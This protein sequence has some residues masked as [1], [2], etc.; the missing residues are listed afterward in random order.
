MGL[1]EN[2]VIF[3]LEFSD[4]PAG[5]LVFRIRRFLVEHDSICIFVSPEC[6]I[7]SDYPAS[8]FS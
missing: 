3:S 2:L 4:N 7:F 1:W 5:F 6:N 8:T